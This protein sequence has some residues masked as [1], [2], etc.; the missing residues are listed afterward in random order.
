MVYSWLCSRLPI[1]LVNLAYSF[2]YAGLLLLLVY[3]WERPAA[4]FLYLHL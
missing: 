2:W 1:N 4:A 3:L